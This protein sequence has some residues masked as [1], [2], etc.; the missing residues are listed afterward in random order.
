MTVIRVTS[1]IVV[2]ALIPLP[3]WIIAASHPKTDT[4]VD[5][6]AA[7]SPAA[8]TEKFTP[9]AM[10]QRWSLIGG[11]KCEW[12]IRSSG[13]AA[14]SRGLSLECDAN[15]DQQLVLQ[16]DAKIQTGRWTLRVD[17]GEQ[18]PNWLP[19]SGYPALRVT[20]SE[21]YRFLIYSDDNGSAISITDV[22]FRPA[23]D[24]D[25]ELPLAWPTSGPT[26]ERDQQRLL[27]TWNAVFGIR[28]GDGVVAKAKA[29]TNFVYQH[30]NVR[31]GSEPVASGAPRDWVGDPP[32][33]ING[34]CGNFAD[35]TRKFCKKVGITVRIAN[36]ATKGFAEGSARFDTHVLVEVFD[37]ESQR[38]FLA[39][40]TFNLTFEGP[41]G[42]LLGLQGLLQTAADGKIWRAVPIAALRP[43]R[44]TEDYYL[45][46][47]D[48]LY[49]GCVPPVPS[50]GDS[51]IEF[52]THG[53]TIDE[54]ARA[55]YPAPKTHELDPN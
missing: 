37:P 16:I 51:G 19:L 2:A 28:D 39:D 6:G 4:T 27:A 21:R 53:Q 35:A 50:L 40:P 36:L 41:N 10:T 24:A 31:S 26:A 11:D 44:T 33:Q 18:A 47:A 48:L 54:M 15:P 17:D 52:R 30:S 5:S 1:I 38:W 3:I 14:G 20:G 46:Y 49:A 34:A 25:Y 22:A 12:V 42:E 32:R 7:D 29:I 55:K 23:A 8:V 43:G 13:E 45:R 9:P